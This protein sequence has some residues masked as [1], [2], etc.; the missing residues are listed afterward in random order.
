MPFNT[1]QK[2]WMPNQSICSPRLPGTN[3][4]LASPR[5][6]TPTSNQFVTIIYILRNNIY[7][8]KYC[9]IGYLVFSFIGKYSFLFLP[10]L[11]YIIWCIYIFLIFVPIKMIL[12]FN[13]LYI[14][15]F[16]NVF[17]PLSIVQG[18]LGFKQLVS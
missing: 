17:S 12:V 4:T 3:A 11:M 6:S 15:R 9:N 18:P 2:K 7:F 5:L 1:P 10:I 14:Y 16:G 13:L 8:L